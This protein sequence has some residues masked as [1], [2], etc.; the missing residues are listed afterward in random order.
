MLYALLISVI[1]GM[2][3]SFY[4]SSIVE[5]QKNLISQKE[6]LTAQ[7]MARLTQ[8]HADEKSGQI[9][10]NHGIS[11][12]QKVG[13]TLNVTVKLENAVTY[14]FDFSNITE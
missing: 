13:K 2:I 7:L 11:D 14:H 10:F 6:F 4:L 8:E 5:N 1:F 3:L 12:Y 9:R